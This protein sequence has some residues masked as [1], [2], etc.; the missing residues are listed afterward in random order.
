MN[1]SGFPYFIDK[2]AFVKGYG[3]NGKVQEIA[4]QLWAQ[5]DNNA[6]WFFDVMA[7]ISVL[8]CWLYYGPYNKKKSGRPYKLRWLLGFGVLASIIVG[9]VTFVWCNSFFDSLD[10][11]NGVRMHIS[12]INS[13]CALAVYALASVITCL[14][15]PTN[16]YRWLPKVM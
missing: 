11:V 14:F 2:V 8:L 13:L 5:L 12:L 1:I 10:D 6:D 3:D 15:F 4:E 7:V 16:A 9:V